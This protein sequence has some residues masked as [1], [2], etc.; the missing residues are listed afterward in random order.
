MTDIQVLSNPQ[1]GEIR[2]TISENDKPM[3]CLAD[4]CKALELT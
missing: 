2:I 3:F 4:V 1:F